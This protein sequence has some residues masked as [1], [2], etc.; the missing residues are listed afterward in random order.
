M[1][2]TMFLATIVAVTILGLAT[3][4]IALNY[5]AEA[6]HGEPLPECHEGDAFDPNSGD[7][8]PIE[9]CPSGLAFDDYV[10]HCALAGDKN[11]PCDALDKENK[12]KAKGKERAKA[13]NDC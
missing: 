10:P 12:G 8:I 11:N 13:N 1:T 3:S 4:S 7:C 6:D 2:K 5:T 9:D